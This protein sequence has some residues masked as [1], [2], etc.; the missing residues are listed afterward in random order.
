MIHILTL[1]WN[2]LDKLQ[3]LK[4]GL[5]NNLNQLDED[6]CWYIRD[7]G[8]KDKTVEEILTWDKV[9]TLTIDHNRDNFAQGV[10]SLFKTTNCNPNDLI[11]LLNNDVQFTDDLSLRKMRELVTEEHGA[12]GAR[13]LYDGTNVLQHAGVIWSLKYGGNPYHYRHKE[14][15]DYQ[16][17]RNRYFQA[18][19]AACCFV[20]AKDFIAIGGMD[21]KLVWCFDD[22]D[23]C[24]AL[25]QLGKKNVYCGETKI[26]HEESA[27]LK[28]NPVN[29]LFMN[30]NVTYFKTKWAGKYE[31]DHEKYLQN[32][33]YQIL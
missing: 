18:V 33:D 24:L 21:E 19:T 23:M 14:E 4:D 7:N 15:S 13:L 29:K 22:I 11:L 6:Y 16:A 32:S 9:K 28:K 25:K 17:E 1:T 20:K 10:N 31:I 8:S 26:F 5:F 2:G 3:K 27:S 30:S 12:V